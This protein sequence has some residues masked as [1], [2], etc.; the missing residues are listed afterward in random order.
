MLV[1]GADGPLQHHDT[2]N[3]AVKI[4]NGQHLAWPRPGF[5]LV[6]GSAPDST[7]LSF[8]PADEANV[9]HRAATRIQRPF[10]A[11]TGVLVQLASVRTSEAGG[12]RPDMSYVQQPWNGFLKTGLVAQRTAVKGSRI[13][14]A[15]RRFRQVATQGRGSRLIFIKYGPS[16]A[17]RRDVRPRAKRECRSP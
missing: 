13:D 4:M 2:A 15:I 9:A 7:G 17:R 1:V 3:K 8:E 11:V 12:Q 5:R 10:C 16:E 6:A 14:G